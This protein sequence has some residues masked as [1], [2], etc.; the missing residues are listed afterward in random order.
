[1]VSKGTSIG[2]AVDP[3]TRER[4]TQLR[5]MLIRQANAAVKVQLTQPRAPWQG[6]ASDLTRSASPV[7]TQELSVPRQASTD[8][9]KTRSPTVLTPLSSSVPRATSRRPKAPP[10]ALPRPA[11]EAFSYWG[12]PP[13][14]AG[15]EAPPTLVS[16]ADR[17]TFA[18]LVAAGAGTTPAGDGEELF[19]TIGL[20]FGTSSTKV[21]VRFPYETGVPT[22]AIPAPAHCL[23]SGNP[24]LWQ[25]VLWVDERGG[26]T[27]WPEPGARPLDM[28]KQGVMNGQVD[29]KIACT[30]AGG[31]AIMA[32]DAAAAFLT[33]VI[34]YTRGWLLTNRPQLFRRRHPVWFVNVGL[35]AAT[36]DGHDLVANYRRIAAAALLLANSKG[37]VTV[38]ATRTFLTHSRVTLAGD[39]AADAESLGVAIVPET[40]AAV[41]GFAK[42][43]NRA[44][45]LYLMV[46]VG[47]MTLDVCAFRL[48]ERSP[49][50]DLYALFAAQVRPLGVEAY[51]WFLGEG[52]TEAGFV[53]QCTR[54][55]HQVT[56]G[57]KKDRDPNAECWRKGNELPVFLIGGGAD[58]ELHRSV[59]EELHPWLRRHSQNEG[60]RLLVLPVPS[61]IDLL[62]PLSQFGRLAVAWGL[63]FP[64]TEIGEILPPSTIESVLPAETKDTS[65]HFVSKELV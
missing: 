37:T 42:S 28:L 39:S 36:Y 58:N 4:L 1:M 26:F 17:E 64:V 40:A 25:T 16:T 38:E 23:S 49:A 33:F 30:L 50:D 11:Q 43:T 63:S 31:E 12:L 13:E 55:L 52:R 62:T 47:A 10:R 3:S 59:V 14:A 32:A 56:W 27:A 57:T 51:H 22:I 15:R 18:H 8:V 41:A 9:Q 45:G 65:G 60:I 21:I 5:Q 20:D 6:P 19:A 44:T 2:D 48:A 7:S 24:Y 35:P 29:L 61:N 34:R 53:E 46:D 54:C